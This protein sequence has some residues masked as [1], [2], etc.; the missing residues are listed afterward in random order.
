MAAGNAKNKGSNEPDYYSIIAGKIVGTPG[1]LERLLGSNPGAALRDALGSVGITKPPPG[2]INDLIGELNVFKGI[3]FDGSDGVD[4]IL[5]RAQMYLADD[6]SL[7]ADETKSL[8]AQM[9]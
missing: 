5:S 1:F 3:S 4:L 6:S 7:R 8:Q 9:I 2:L